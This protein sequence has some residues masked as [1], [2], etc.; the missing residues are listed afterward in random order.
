LI[1]GVYGVHEFTAEFFIGV[2]TCFEGLLELFDVG[3]E[4][5]DCL[6]GI[7]ILAKKH[8]AQPSKVDKLLHHVNVSGWGVYL[9]LVQGF[10]FLD[11]LTFAFCLD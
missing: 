5:I 10:Y 3:G 9:L 6:R 2:L 11:Q 1:A 7:A 8:S 4:C